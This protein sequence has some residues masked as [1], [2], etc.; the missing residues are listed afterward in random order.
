MTST[1]PESRPGAGG[2]LLV[3]RLRG[4][5]MTVLAGG[6]GVVQVVRS[7][8]FSIGSALAGLVLAAHT[9]AGSTFPTETGFTTAAW[10]GTAAMTLA[11]VI[12]LA[13]RRTATAPSA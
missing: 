8:G 10:A 12:S 3:P 2:R 13:L 7:V 6:S 9:G 5:A 1:A 11:M 4:R